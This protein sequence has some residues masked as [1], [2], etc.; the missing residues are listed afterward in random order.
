MPYH[1]SLFFWYRECYGCE[2][3]FFTFRR[4]LPYTP[5]CW[6]QALP[7][8]GCS[9]SKLAGL[10]ADLRN[11]APVQLF[12][13]ITTIHKRDVVVGS[14]YGLWLAGLSNEESA[15]YSI[16]TLFTLIEHAKSLMFYLF[17]H[18]TKHAVLN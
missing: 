11:I 18:R 1:W 6:F 3:A 10:H 2:R 12:V 17:G 14:I 8:I 9:T 15:S 16:W 4:F 5:S 7:R 13:W